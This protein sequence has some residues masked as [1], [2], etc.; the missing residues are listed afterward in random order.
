VLCENSMF[1]GTEYRLKVD[2]LE[3]DLPQHLMVGV[4]CNMFG[5]MYNFVFLLVMSFRNR[6]GKLNGWG[7]KRLLHFFCIVIG[8]LRELLYVE[9]D[10]A[11]YI[12][13]YPEHL[14]RK[15]GDS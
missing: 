5:Y 12:A 11:D 8:I 13:R 4:V 6:I 9:D 14:S 15:T 2:P 10:T 3:V 1:K 7:R